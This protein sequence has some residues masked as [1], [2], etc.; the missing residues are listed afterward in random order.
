MPKL[1]KKYLK[2]KLDEALAKMLGEKLMETAADVMEASLAAHGFHNAHY[3]PGK[4]KEEPSK[5]P[6]HKVGAKVRFR[7]SS[8]GEYKHTGTVTHFH[9]PNEYGHYTVKDHSTGESHKLAWHNIAKH[10]EV[11]EAVDDPLLLRKLRRAK[12]KAKSFARDRADK[13]QKH[14]SLGEDQGDADQ[15]GPMKVGGPRDSQEHEPED[16]KKYLKTEASITR[17]HFV[18][19]ADKLKADKATLGAAAHKAA[20]HAHADTFAKKN[21]RFDRAKFLKHA[22]VDESLKEGYA[23]HF[24]HAYKDGKLTHSSTHKNE[25]D[26]LKAFKDHKKSHPD[27]YIY[28]SDKAGNSV[29]KHTP[30]K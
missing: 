25:V 13:Y 9:G 19:T 7:K 22:G 18:A 24:V 21:P 29:R 4:P 12:R 26:A 14:S 16:E 10:K 28:H 23:S 8:D 27:H 6:L 2:A 5:E 1:T 30:G 3:Q 20:A 15:K 11:T 17:K